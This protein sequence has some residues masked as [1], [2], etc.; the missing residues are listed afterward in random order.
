MMQS[1]LAL[2]NISSEDRR[3]TERHVTNLKV[4][5]VVLQSGQELCVLRTLSAQGAKA[6]VAEP[7]DINEEVITK[8]RSGEL[9]RG[10][11]VW[12]PERI[13]AG[14]DRACKSGLLGSS[15]IAA[16]LSGPINVRFEQA[17]TGSRMTDIGAY[18]VEKV[19]SLNFIARSRNE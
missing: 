4:A 6:D 14:H 5:K 10:R 17:L 15:D 2:N 13:A 7:Y 19:S 8:L 16:N 12:L 11:V 3:R 1:A 9:I 18:S